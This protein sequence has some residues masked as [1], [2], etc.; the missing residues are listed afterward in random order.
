MP[1]KKVETVAGSVD[2]GQSQQQVYENPK[3]GQSPQNLKLYR[4]QESRS[5]E[6]NERPLE[7]I[8]SEKPQL[9]SEQQNPSSTSCDLTNS[10]VL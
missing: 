3:E 10:R 4:Q 6:N 7:I 1:Q 8:L 2:D 5:L 9:P